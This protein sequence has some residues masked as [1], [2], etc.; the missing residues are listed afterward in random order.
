MSNYAF[1]SKDPGHWGESY[2]SLWGCHDI[3][4]LQEQ[5]HITHMTQ[6]ELASL[7]CLKAWGNDKKF[8]SDVAFLLVLPT[9]GAVGER[10][11]G[12]AM[13]WVHPYQAMVSMIDDAAK[14]LA[15]LT[16]T[17]TNWPYSLVQ[18]NGDDHHVPLP[19]EGHLSVM[20]E[21]NT[22]NIPCRKIC[23]LK[24]CQ[25]LSSD[26]WVVY[27]EGLNGCQVPVIM[28]LPELLSNGM[29]MLK[30]E[31][32]FLQVDLSQS[33]TKEQ[34]S[35]ALSL[36][37]GLSPT[38]ARSP[39][40]A[41]PPKAESQ[42]SMTMEVSKLL[43]QAVLDTS[44]LASRSS[45][46][47]R[48]GSLALAA[49]L[50]LKPEASIKPVDTSSQVSV[51]DDVEM[52][53]A[54]LEEIHA[55]PS[56]LVKTP[57]SSSEAPSLDVTQLQEEANKALGYLLATRSSIDTHQRKQVLD[58]GMALHQIESE[59]TETIKEAKAL[60]AH[61][62]R[63][64]ETHQ[65]VLISKVKIQHAACIKEIEDNCVHALAEVENCCST[66]IREAES[67]GASP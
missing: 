26:S 3:C 33:A 29:T 59:T 35:R 14:Q 57:G 40:R 52:D 34:E 46:P 66:A 42:I 62:I 44:C 61:T 6:L 30:G 60:C 39:T 53:N 37:S 45:T 41:L 58:F 27:L 7:T 9:E 19:T 5:F 54:T 31:P 13:V 2:Q 18:L 67:Q 4:P 28:S 43:S 24:V 11:Y 10:V 15:Q 32:T 12:L 23:Q 49:P 50:P 55:S 56:P 48:P 63:D 17:G 1:F 64:V 22:S 16:S 25:L 21:G 65:A 20:M 47:N 51:P 38:P 36:A 8:C